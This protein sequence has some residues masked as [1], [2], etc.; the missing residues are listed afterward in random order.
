ML[1]QPYNANVAF[2]GTGRMG[3][4][5]K[6]DLYISITAFVLSESLL[7][8]FSKFLVR[9]RSLIPGSFALNCGEREA[10]LP[11][12]WSFL[13]FVWW[14]AKLCVFSLSSFRL[15]SRSCC[16]RFGFIETSRFFLL[17]SR[18]LPILYDIV[19]D[20]QGYEKGGRTL[21]KYRSLVRFTFQRLP[22][23]AVLS[24][25]CFFPFL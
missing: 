15:L 14:S 11:P 8:L 17:S 3:D 1:R 5:W 22:Y 21:E 9:P 2:E 10:I 16:W 24:Q 20:K 4:S 18:C 12:L 23:M 25:T 7:P 19:I 13:P 6:R